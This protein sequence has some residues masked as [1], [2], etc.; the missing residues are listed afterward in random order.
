MISYI[1]TLDN[2]NSVETEWKNECQGGVVILCPRG[3]I[4]EL[5][6]H[7]FIYPLFFTYKLIEIERERIEA[8]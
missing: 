7:R 5:F 6:P 1:T 3:I 8:F 2:W 4:I